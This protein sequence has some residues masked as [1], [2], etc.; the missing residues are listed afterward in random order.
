MNQEILKTPSPRY[1]PA[2]YQFVRLALEHALKKFEKRR[3]I[4]GKELL[5]SI[6]EYAK[7]RFGSLSRLVFE[8]WGIYETVDFGNV[9]FELVDMGVMSKRPED[10]I[11][12]FKNIFDFRKEFEETYDYVSKLRCSPQLSATPSNK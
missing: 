1:H 4:S 2:A 8:E 11:D 9:V 7:R 6:S 12:D 10:S 3:H 5:G